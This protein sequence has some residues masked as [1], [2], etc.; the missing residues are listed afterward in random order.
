MVLGLLRDVSKATR[1][2]ISARKVCHLKSVI[3]PCLDFIYHLPTTAS[4]YLVIYKK[5]NDY[6]ICISG[7]AVD[8]GVGLTLL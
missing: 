1:K 8:V 6:L 4:D 2:T 3:H 5:D 7:A